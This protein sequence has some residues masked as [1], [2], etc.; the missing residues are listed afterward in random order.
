MLS[1]QVIVQGCGSV[2]KSAITI[3]FVHDMFVSKYDPTI[4]DSYRKPFQ[5]AGE[6]FVLEIVDTAGTD[7][8]A[9]MRDLY[10]KNGDAFLLVCAIDKRASIEDIKQLR[11]EILDIKNGQP[12]MVIAV[13]KVDLPVERHE[14][15]EAEIQQLSKRF[16]VPYFFTSA[17]NNTNIN[18]VFVSLSEQIVQGVLSGSK[19]SRNMKKSSR[20]ALL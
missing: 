8:F 2:G 19:K 18:E 13:N 15:S 3:R 1:H 17:A 6:H 16:N 20:C 4:E 11:S 10:M 5:L 14:I 9:S 12:P 7:Q